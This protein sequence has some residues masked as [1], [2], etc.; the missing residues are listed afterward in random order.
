MK[1]VGGYLFFFGVG[2]IV[3]YFLD[4]EFIILSW[5]D[6]WGPTTGWA[7]RIAMSVVGGVLWLL[8]QRQEA[9]AT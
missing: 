7:I 8:G 5:I 4:M 9:E 6:M 3:L 1:K 2:S